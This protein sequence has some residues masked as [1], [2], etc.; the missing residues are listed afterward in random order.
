MNVNN[1]NTGNN[2]I[3]VDPSLNASL[4]F[5]VDPNLANDG[6]IDMNNGDEDSEDDSDDANMNKGGK[7]DIDTK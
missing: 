1:N 6:D 5:G 2:G 7:G 4:G 3:V